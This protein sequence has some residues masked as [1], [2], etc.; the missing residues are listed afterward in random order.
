MMKV[1]ALVDILLSQ[2]VYCTFSFVVFWRR[3]ACQVSSIQYYRPHII[4][5]G[6]D[7][8]RR[9]LF[10]PRMVGDIRVDPFWADSEWFEKHPKLCIQT[11]L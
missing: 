1:V 9:N 2:L 8:I 4:L 6:I 7:G 5:S 11:H 3:L 10:P